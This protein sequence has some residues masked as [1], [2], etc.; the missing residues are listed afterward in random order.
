MHTSE[1]D[2]NTHIEGLSSSHTAGIL[3]QDN[4]LFERLIEAIDDDTLLLITSDHGLIESGHGGI[5]P[6]ERASFVFAYRKKGLLKSHPFMKTYF[7]E[8]MELNDLDNFDLTP[9]VSLLLNNAPPFNA[10][11]DLLSEVLPLD[12][13]SS[14]REVARHLLR[15][16]REVLDQKIKLAHELREINREHHDLLD[17]MVFLDQ[18]IEALLARTPTEQDE[19]RY[20]QD[21]VDVIKQVKDKINLFKQYTSTRATV[22]DLSSAKS[23]MISTIIGLSGVIF[24]CVKYFVKEK[25]S[26]S[27]NLGFRVMGFSILAGLFLSQLL[28]ITFAAGIYAA[29]SV[30]ITLTALFEALAVQRLFAVL[31]SIVRTIKIA[32]EHQRTGVILLSGFVTFRIIE[33]NNCIMTE[34]PFHSMFIF[35]LLLDYF[36]CTIS[37]TIV[38]QAQKQALSMAGS[39]LRRLKYLAVEVF[40]LYLMSLGDLTLIGT[41]KSS[42]DGFHR[43]FEEKA[44]FIGTVIP[45]TI[46]FAVAMHFLVRVYKFRWG[47]VAL[48]SVQYVGSLACVHFAQVDALWG[49]QVVPSAILLSTVYGVWYNLKANRHLRLA[50][51][52]QLIVV[53]VS[54]MPVLLFIGGHYST[55]NT[56]LQ[57]SLLALMFSFEKRPT[58]YLMFNCLL[59]TRMA[60]YAA[61]QRLTL[62]GLCLNCGTLFYNEY[63]GLSWLVVMLKTLYPCVLGGLF[64][65]V[66][67]LRHFEFRKTQA[68]AADSVSPDLEA[69]K[70]KQLGRLSNLDKVKEDGVVWVFG[71][72]MAQ[73]ILTVSDA[74]G[75]SI[76][77]TVDSTNVMVYQAS[78]SYLYQFQLFVLMIC[79]K[80][81]FIGL[82]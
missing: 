46:L 60:F 52:H 65:L 34:H 12:S 44:F 68:A 42:L 22:Y 17:S 7:P 30:A 27:F 53:L 75:N 21:C 24:N 2:H 67:L 80:L 79:F 69:A 63:H 66:M 57:F 36:L 54:V 45:G 37:M 58:L 4:K 40:L 43:M 71:Y 14:N 23:V 26:L 19:D 35:K 56:V 25:S 47:S 20:I 33:N 5:S 55:Y 18:R 70:A 3:T 31:K 11:G 59:A 50:K 81:L 77:F 32:L 64:Y 73:N 76:L 41:F 72:F 62:N 61:G 39:L 38:G 49:R 48:F 82:K 9:T 28:H 8:E 74:L 29:L 1:L 6:E 78:S 10:I 13:N 16:R 15:M 51:Y